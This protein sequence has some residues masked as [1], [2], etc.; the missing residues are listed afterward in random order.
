[1]VYGLS[2]V[3]LILQEKNRLSKASFFCALFCV[4][5]CKFVWNVWC[6]K[7]IIAASS[8]FQAGGFVVEAIPFLLLGILAA[9]CK[10]VVFG[11]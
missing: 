7:C 9:N 5:A 11:K 1:M 3:S 4:V 6:V 8:R 2:H 10:S